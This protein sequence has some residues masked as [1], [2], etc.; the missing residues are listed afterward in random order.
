[1]RDSYKII[2]AE[3]CEIL[4]MKVNRFLNEKFKNEDGEPDIGEIWEAIGGPMVDVGPGHSG[5]WYQA[6]RFKEI[7]VKSLALLRTKI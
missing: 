2:R 4:E 6:V 1:M 3:N 7:H 5:S